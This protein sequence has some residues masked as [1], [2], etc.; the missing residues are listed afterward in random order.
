M[1]EFF[2]S[3]LDKSWNPVAN[4]VVNLTNHKSVP[5]V[6]QVLPSL[7]LKCDVYIVNVEIGHSSDLPMNS[8]S[9]SGESLCVNC[10]ILYRNVSYIKMSEQDAKADIDQIY[11]HRKTWKGE[12]EGVSVFF[13]CNAVGLGSTHGSSVDGVKLEFVKI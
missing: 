4:K 2:N 13:E 12:S 6:K 1:I 7:L 3:C 10:E 9:C 8:I 5:L 11:L